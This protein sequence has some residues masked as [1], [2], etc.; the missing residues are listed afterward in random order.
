M[1]PRV[2]ILVLLLSA[3]PGRLAFAA[4][5][6]REQARAKLIEGAKFTDAGD[7]AR[8]LEKFEE[9]YALVPSP[10]IFFN[11]GIAYAGLGRNG[12]AYDAYERF[13]HEATEANAS[14][15]A[16]ARQELDRIAKMIGFLA[17]SANVAGPEVFL[18]GR[19]MGA[20]PLYNS[21][22][23]DP[24]P[25]QL[26][27]RGGGF[28]TQERRLVIAAGGKQDLRL[29]IVRGEP[30]VAVARPAV[31]ATAVTAAATPILATASRR[32]MRPARW[33]GVGATAAALVTGLTFNLLAVSKGNEFEDHARNPMCERRPEGITSSDGS[34]D[35][36]KACLDLANKKQ[37]YQS[38]AYTSYVVSG[39]LALGTVALFV[40][41][42]A[43]G[44]ELA[45]RYDVGSAAPSLT[46]TARF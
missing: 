4:P 41:A 15:R 14:T 5:S 21:I 34:K 33:V 37:T 6:E 8:G 16:Q 18:D 20:L 19:R 35:G 24:G 42:P 22:P 11:L 40:L 23:L 10:K 45:L 25:H 7:F 2:Y 12:E 1:L 31:P 17:V 29:E 26:L 3:L 30:A 13:L 43:E 9:A 27:V 44:T 32:W 38:V 36:A 28:V 39:A 46:Y